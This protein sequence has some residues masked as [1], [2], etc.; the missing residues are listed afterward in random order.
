MN[1]L[2]DLDGTLTDPK[3]GIVKS[4]RYAL[5][6]MDVLFDTDQS[7]DW[8]IGPPLRESFAKLIK[9]QDEG[10]LHRAVETYRLRF[11]DTGIYEN[12]VYDGIP[13]S[14]AQL[15]GKHTLYV[16]TSKPAVFAEEII[17][18]FGLG[19]YFRAIY[20]SELNG[21]NSDKTELLA[22]LIVKEGLNAADC[23]MIGDREHDM[24]GAK[25]NQIMAVGIGWGYG[26]ELELINSGASTVLKAPS[27]LK[28]HAW[29]S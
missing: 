10:V 27:D 5:E 15:A 29:I 11:R 14:L 9:T 16:A 19:K 6:K 2:F 13:E 22:K 25:N 3:E 12:R 23:V 8:C 26:S 24:V 20:G 18:H 4:I 17:R 1:L 7:L 21:D 28:G